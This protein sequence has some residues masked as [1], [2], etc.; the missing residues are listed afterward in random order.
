MV[1]AVLIMLVFA[2]LILRGYQIA[3]RAPD[4]FGT[5]LAAGITTQLAVQ[6]IFHLCVVTGL[7]P[8]TGAALPFFSYGGTSLL[9]LLGEAGIVLGVSRR[10]P[11]PEQG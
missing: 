3:L 7:V 1:G 6:T 11:A 4:R 10:I 8:V 2:A 9:M 5:L